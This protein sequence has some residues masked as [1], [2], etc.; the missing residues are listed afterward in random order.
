MLQGLLVKLGLQAYGTV[1]RVG[2]YL[3]VVV[4]LFGSG[5]VTGCNYQSDK[6]AA[7]TTSAIV[8]QVKDAPK[9]DKKVT[10]RVAEVKVVHDKVYIEVEKLVPANSC[11]PLGPDVISLLNRN[12]SVP[13]LP[14]NDETGAAAATN[15]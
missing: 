4:L 10:D 9:Q 8:S 6:T 13:S 12:R 5:F 11:P 14:R 2:L 7:K 3:A 1:I 15:R